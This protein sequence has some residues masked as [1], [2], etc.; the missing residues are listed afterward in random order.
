MPR[1]ADAKGPVGKGLNLD[2][3]SI[4]SNGTSVYTGHSV[5]KVYIKTQ[6]TRANDKKGG[7][8]KKVSIAT[9]MMVINRK[10]NI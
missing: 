8:P 7:G 6:L 4:Y 9:S 3:I 2:L 1:Y 5:H 10:I